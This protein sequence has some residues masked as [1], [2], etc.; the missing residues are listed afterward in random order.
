[1]TVNAIGFS[2][3]EREDYPRILAIMEDSYLLARTYD[4]FLQAAEDGERALQAK[5]MLVI[6]AIIKPDEF[7]AWC[8]ENHLQL[9]SKARVR[10]ANDAAA[11]EVRRRQEAG[12][13]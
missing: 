1:M 7:S 6:R 12:E 3:Y 8:R 11:A 5:G 9:E 2:W 10:F 13:G 4:E